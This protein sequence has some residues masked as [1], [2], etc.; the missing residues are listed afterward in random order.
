MAVCGT[1]KTVARVITFGTVDRGRRPSASVPKAIS[2]TEGQ[3]FP[4]PQT[5]MK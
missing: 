4:I 1:V 3:Q 2:Y 5:P